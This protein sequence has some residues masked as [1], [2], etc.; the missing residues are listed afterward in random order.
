MN[1]TASDSIIVTFSH[2]ENI[3]SRNECC[4]VAAVYLILFA[5]FFAWD[6]A[7]NLSMRLYIALFVLLFTQLFAN[8]ANASPGHKVVADQRKSHATSSE[9]ADRK[10]RKPATSKKEKTATPTTT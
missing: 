2:K 7:W 5:M 9:S 3:N 10:K 4:F 1:K 8:A 6:K